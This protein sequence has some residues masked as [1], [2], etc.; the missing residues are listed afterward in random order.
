L[1]L[2]TAERAWGRGIAILRAKGAYPWSMSS[3]GARNRT[4]DAVIYALAPWAIVLLIVWG[5]RRLLRELPRGHVV[6]RRWYPVWAIGAGG[7]VIVLGGLA[8]SSSL[9]DGDYIRVGSSGVFLVTAMLALIWVAKRS[10]PD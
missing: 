10:Q 7:A 3:L 5:K 6:S 1:G 9:A 2:R 4:L 8:I